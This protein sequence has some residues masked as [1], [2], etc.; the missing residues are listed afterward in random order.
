MQTLL[1]WLRHQPTNL[2]DW[3][4]LVVIVI[5]GG[6]FMAGV[7]FAQLGR[8]PAA[9]M[10][11][12]TL[13]VAEDGHWGRGWKLVLFVMG[14]TV[15]YQGIGLTFAVYYFRADS[16]VLLSA[17]GIA[18]AQAL[19][20]PHHHLPAQTRVAVWFGALILSLIFLKCGGWENTWPMLNAKA[21]IITWI[22]H[23]VP[24]AIISIAFAMHWDRKSP[25][26]NQPRPP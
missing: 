19:L 7:A 12:R 11:E 13:T 3:L 10:Y 4:E 24:V 5:M 15:L 25:P 2:S 14:E 6:L 23:L 8:N 26:K 9:V 22:A 16:A 1:A 21:L 17:R 18:T 20:P